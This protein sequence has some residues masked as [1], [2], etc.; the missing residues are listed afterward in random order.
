MFQAK[1][2]TGIDLGEVLSTQAVAEISYEID[3]EVVALLYNAAKAQ[4][5]AEGHTDGY[6]ITWSKQLPVGVSKTEHYEGFAEV[7]EDASRVIYDRT[8]KHAAN[9]MVISSTI[10]PILS[11]MRGWKA[12]STGSVNGPY[13]AGTLNGIKVYVSPALEAGD[14]FLGFNGDDLIT[15]AAVYAPLGN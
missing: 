5:V 11:L 13:F 14:F 15:S 12:A 10:K 8:K 7:L 6:N 3:T 4:A 2:E 9:Y 1:T